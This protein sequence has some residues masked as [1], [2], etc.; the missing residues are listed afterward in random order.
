MMVP[1]SGLREEPKTI[2]KY[3]FDVDGVDGAG[4]KEGPPSEF[5]KE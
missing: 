4:G 3:E 2:T 5:R 1:S